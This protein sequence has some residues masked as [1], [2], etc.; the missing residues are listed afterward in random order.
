MASNAFDYWKRRSENGPRHVPS[1]G[2]DHN[3]AKREWQIRTGKTLFPHVSH[4]FFTL[5]IVSYVT[6]QHQQRMFCAWFCRRVDPNESFLAWENHAFVTSDIT[7][8]DMMCWHHASMVLGSVLRG[9][10]PDENLYGIYV[11]FAQGLIRF[12]VMK[13]Q[14]HYSGWVLTCICNGTVWLWLCQYIE[15][16][17]SRAIMKL[18]RFKKWPSDPAM[19]FKR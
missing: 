5:K 17:V 10:D 4:V 2:L 8:I 11:R 9:V 6:L 1:H 7:S 3:P 16:E 18:P 12:Q 14:K 13:N 19:N 15:L